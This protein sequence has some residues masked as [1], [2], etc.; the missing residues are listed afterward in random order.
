[1]LSPVPERYA[2]HLF[3]SVNEPYSL[4]LLKGGK[5]VFCIPHADAA[6]IKWRTFPGLKYR[7]SSGSSWL[8]V[9]KITTMIR[10]EIMDTTVGVMSPPTAVAVAW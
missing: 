10:M 5:V 9:A 7:L 2:I 3:I 8:L 6:E 4:I 1:M